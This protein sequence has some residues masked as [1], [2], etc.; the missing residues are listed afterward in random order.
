MLTFHLT[1]FL[2]LTLYLAYVLAFYLA[3]RQA[4]I[5]AFYLASM[6]ALILAFYLWPTASGACD[7]GS[8]VAHST[9]EMA[10]E[11]TRTEGRRRN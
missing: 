2:D 5:L 7:I 3:S 8:I 1:F 6:Q 9:D 11:E 4:F 10:E